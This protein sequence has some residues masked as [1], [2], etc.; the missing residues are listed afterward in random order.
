MTI[1]SDVIGESLEVFMDDFSVFRP[2]VD[3]CLENLT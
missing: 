2:S 1:F 3:T